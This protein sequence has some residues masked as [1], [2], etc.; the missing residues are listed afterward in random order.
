MPTLAR[1][2]L[3]V[4]VMRGIIRHR[5][6]RIDEQVEDDLLELDDV[7]EDTR[8]AP[9]STWRV[10]RRQSF[11]QTLHQPITSIVLLSADHGRSSRRGGRASRPRQPPGRSTTPGFRLSGRFA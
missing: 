2:Q 11:R 9:P 1:S 6:R 7:S 3:D 5:L 8:R 10:N 4:Q